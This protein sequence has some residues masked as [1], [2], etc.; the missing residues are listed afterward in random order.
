MGAFAAASGEIAFPALENAL[1]HRFK[2]DLAEKNIEAARRAYDLVKGGCLRWRWNSGA[3]PPREGP[4]EQDRLLAR[5]QT[6]SSTHEKCT[7]CGMCQT[8]C[9]EGCIS[10]DRGTT[11]SSPDYDYCKGCGLCAE[12]CPGEAIT[13]EQEEK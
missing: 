6:D 10:E 4:D 5:F 13:M 12:E 7:K 3:R 11:C 9:P 1:R 8:V 2:G